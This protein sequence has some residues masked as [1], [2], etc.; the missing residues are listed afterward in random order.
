MFK[1]V[2]FPDWTV[3][4]VALAFILIAGVFISVVVRVFRSPKKEI[5]RLSRL[6]L[7]NDHTDPDK[8]S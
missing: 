8:P 7:E 6:P 4:V 2:H 3:V 5:D 1:N